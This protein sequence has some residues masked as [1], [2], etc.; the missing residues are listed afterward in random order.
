MGLPMM[1]IITEGVCM[2][3][4]LPMAKCDLNLS[5]AE[6]GF[7]YAVT[8]VGVVLSSHFWGFLA[9]TW[10]RH[11][12]LKM[13]TLLC[14]IASATSSFVMHS[15][16]LAVTRLI[17]GLWYALWLIQMHSEYNINF[18]W[19]NYSA[20]WLAFVDLDLRIL[21]NFTVTNPDQNINPFWPVST[22]SE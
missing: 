11:K 17:V 21:A 22:G 15:W 10:G 19:N 9:D 12:V 13:A 1:A 3:F 16:M 2:S 20:V 4:A 5:T 6:Q 14:C 18:I 8:D 7:I